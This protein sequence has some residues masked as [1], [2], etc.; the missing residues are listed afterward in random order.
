VQV[1]TYAFQHPEVLQKSEQLQANRKLKAI[2]TLPDTL[3][4]RVSA[5][6]AKGQ[7]DTLKA[8]AR[9]TLDAA[10]A[11]TLD[12]VIDF[13]VAFPDSVR[14]AVAALFASGRSMACS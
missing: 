11:P 6:I 3:R 8:I 4:T 14:R 10:T 13:V 5:A 7:G 12:S 9:R 2:G 1:V